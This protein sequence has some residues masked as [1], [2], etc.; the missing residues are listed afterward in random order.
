MTVNEIRLQRMKLNPPFRRRAG[1]R[2]HR[3]DLVEKPSFLER[4]FFMAA[5]EGFEPSAPGRRERD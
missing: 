1:F 2:F 3:V 5:G 4:G